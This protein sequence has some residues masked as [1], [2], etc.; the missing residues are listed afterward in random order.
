[1]SQNLHED[2]PHLVRTHYPSLDVIRGLG[3]LLVMWS[4]TSGYW[5]PANKKVSFLQTI[6]G[7]Y[8]V[9]PFHLNGN[10]GHLGVAIFFILSGF[11]TA[12][13]LGKPQ[14]RLE[15]AKK[16]AYR[17]WPML[18]VGVVLSFLYVC[19]CNQMRVKHLGVSDASTEKWLL[20][21]VLLDWLIGG[22]PVMTITWT[23]INELFFYIIVM[24]FLPVASRKPLSFSGLLIVSWTVIVLIIPRRYSSNVFYV[25]LIIIGYLFRLLHETRIDKRI[26][27]IQAIITATFFMAFFQY[28]FPSMMS[29]PGV[30]PIY[31]YIYASIIVLYA[32]MNMK[33]SFKPLSFV[34]KISCSI[35]MLH[36]PVGMSLQYLIAQISDRYSVNTVIA[37]V[38]TIFISFAFTK[39]YESPLINMLKNRAK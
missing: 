11:L 8:F 39:F 2:T 14:T 9:Q 32:S 4:H 25:G 38:I 20:S 26:V 34:G 15:F 5:L 36:I 27:I 18:I 30:E 24:I 29:M 37:I 31:S 12:N 6:W 33:A 3:T 19:F 17:L 16:R 13:S 21:T 35:Y 7:N 22:T 28:R 1:M 23:L 10:G